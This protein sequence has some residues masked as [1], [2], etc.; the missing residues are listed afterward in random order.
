MEAYVNYPFKSKIL[1]YGISRGARALSLGAFNSA[2]H[3]EADA[4]QIY[5]G[6]FLA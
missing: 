4:V 2:G 1:I 5:M 6:L 3:F